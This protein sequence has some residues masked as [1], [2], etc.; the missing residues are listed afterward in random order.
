VAGVELSQILG[1]RRVRLEVGA[2]LRWIG[3]RLVQT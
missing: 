1:V 3:F 2:G